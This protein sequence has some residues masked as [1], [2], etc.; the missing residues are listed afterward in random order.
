MRLIPRDY[1]I[2]AK[3]SVFEYFKKKTGNPVIALPTGTGK[4][5]CIADLCETALKMHC[6][7][8]ILVLTHVKELVD[9]N[10]KEFLELWPTAPA[11]IY[12]AGLKRKDVNNNVIFCGVQSVAKNIKAFGRVDLIIIDE[13]HLVSPEDET[14]YMKV[15]NGLKEVNPLLKVIGYSATPWREG[16]GLITSEGGLFTDIC[17]NAIDMASFNW[18]IKQG[19]LVP[20]I[21]KKTDTIVDLDGVHLKMG[22]FDE[23]ELEIAVDKITFA[24]LQETMIYAPER[25][26]WIIFA[27]SIEHCYKIKQMLDYLGVSNRI[28][29][30]NNKTYKMS[31]DERDKNI[32]DWKNY[33]YTAIINKGILTTGVNHPGLDLIVM[34]RPTASSKLWVQMLGRG[35]RPMYA[36]GFD[37]TLKEGRLASIQ[38]SSKHDCRVLDFGGNI[39]R[40]GAINDPVLPRKK[41]E[42]KGDVPIKI[43]DL[44]G[45][46][47]HISARFCGGE[48]FKTNEGCGAAFQF[49]TELKKTASTEQLIKDD[50][51]IVETFKVDRVTAAIHKKE[52]KPDSVKVSYYCGFKRYS[53][54]VMPEHVGFGRRKANEWWKKRSNLELPETTHELIMMFN[55][56]R[57]PKEIKVW[58]N[59]PY[60]EILTEVFEETQAEP[61][62][63]ADVPF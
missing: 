18:F 14:A 27:V 44:C 11:G 36:Q 23:K 60:P 57:V 62:P 63:Y 39:R 33:E 10:Y 15:I 9:Q 43:C 29:H 48:P 59:K 58:T 37:L 41:G 16:Q 61:L 21:S 42:K 2:A 40:L 54:Y 49:K 56:L 50:S 35:T 26:S 51:P 5:Y 6:R 46:Y 45:N 19:Y 52:G 20:L 12:S 3:Q 38:A 22:D 13:C 25:R 32:K 4:A 8:K 30:S 7:Q 55:L 1:Q 47:N 17:F 24:A 28:V 34:L 53:E 31:G